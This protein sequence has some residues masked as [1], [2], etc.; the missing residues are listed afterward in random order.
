MIVSDRIQAKLN[1]TKEGVVLTARDFS[2]EPQYQMALMKALN[3]FVQQGVLQKVAKGKY[4][5]PVKS[6]FGALP[7]SSAEIAKDFLEKD[8]KTVGYITGTTVFASMGL[9]TQISSVITIGSNTSRRPLQRGS[10]RLTFLLQPNTINQQNIPLLRILDAMKMIK[11]IPASTPDEVT[12]RLIQI[13][14]ELSEAE[15]SRLINLS[16]KYAPFVRALL[17]A[18][19]EQIGIPC[20]KLKASLN[21]ITIYKLN[22]SPATLATRDNWNIL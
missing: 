3:R 7:P 13:I 9:T 12:G 6:V 8:G 4:Y 21:P 11:S 18:I 20:A 22:I 14:S 19:C 15:R 10:N 1:T 5:K 17:G 16:L 2:I